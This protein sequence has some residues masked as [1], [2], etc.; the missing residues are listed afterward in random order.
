L[1][2]T[3]TGSDAGLEIGAMASGRLAQLC[4]ERDIATVHLSNAEVFAGTAT[5]PYVETDPAAPTTAE[6]ISKATLEALVGA[7]PGA[8]LIVR[9]TALFSAHDPNCAPMR[10][11]QAL[12]ARH[13]FTAATDEIVSPTYLPLMVDRL[14]DLMIDGET[15]IWHLANDGA[16]SCAGFAAM[17]AAAAGLDPALIDPVR[18][19]G[20]SRNAALAST[21]GAS[22]G[23]LEPAVAAFVR[24]AQRLRGAASR[25]APMRAPATQEIPSGA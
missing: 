10:A 18:A 19:E 6:G 25:G 14:L 21:R 16:L 11:I 13:R 15:G 9:T 3:A 20:G 23:P 17:V 24:H 2:V 4:G 12:A 8:H 5:E 1:N 7:A 22:L